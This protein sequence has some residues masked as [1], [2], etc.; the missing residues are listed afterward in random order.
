MKKQDLKYLKKEAHDLKP[1]FQI[2]KEGIS[3]NLLEGLDLA[4]SAH[5]LVKVNVL[6]TAPNTKEQL[7]ERIL[8]SLGCELVDSIGRVIVIYRKGEKNL[9]EI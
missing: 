7:I 9:Y 1:I 5:E 8:L 4:L 2:G 6:K 3:E